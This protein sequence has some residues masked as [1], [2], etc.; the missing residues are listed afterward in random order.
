MAHLTDPIAATDLPIVRVTGPQGI[1]AAVPQLLGFVPRDSVVLL[2]LTHGGVRVGPVARMDIFPPTAVHVA[3]PLIDCARRYAEAVILVGY[4]EGDRPD[5]LDV[6]VRALAV[7]EIPVFGVLSVRA[8]LIRDARSQRSMRDDSGVAVLDGSD[9]QSQALAAAG[10][11]AGRRVL[12]DRSE[13]AA[14]IA[15]ADGATERETRAA[16]ADA[17]R[18]FAS[19]VD[20]APGMGPLS[21]PLSRA[22]DRALDAARGEHA[23]GAA[24]SARTAA[25]LI[26]LS[27]HIGCRDELLARCLRGPGRSMVPVL[28]AIA[29]RCPDDAAAELCAVLAAV[30]YRYGDGALAHCALDRALRASPHHRLSGML[31]RA[32][33]SGLPPGDL[34]VLA[35]IH[36]SQRGTDFR[37]A[38]RRR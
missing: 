4:H 17:R 3:Q 21:L 7:H 18:R 26:V 24:V 23:S 10:V 25:E 22:L 13:L 14:S 5:C 35:E 16:M 30:A 38:R 11:L 9:R 8:G 20:A 32:V 36:T 6:I 27:T 2:C 12:G 19:T 1:V 33:D 31:R 29:R 15:L 37:G 34:Q 28:I